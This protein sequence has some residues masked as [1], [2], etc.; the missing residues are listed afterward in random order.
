MDVELETDTHT[1]KKL[2]IQSPSDDDLFTSTRGGFGN[3]G[4]AELLA[5][6]LASPVSQAFGGSFTTFPIDNAQGE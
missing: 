6:G 1:T 5:H 4:H 2:T 3:M